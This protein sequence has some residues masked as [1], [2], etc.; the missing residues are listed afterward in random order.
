ML[1]EVYAGPQLSDPKGG[2]GPSHTI[3]NGVSLLMP[4]WWPLARDVI[5]SEGWPVPGISTHGMENV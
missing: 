4:K 2:H 3:V 5:E 1:E